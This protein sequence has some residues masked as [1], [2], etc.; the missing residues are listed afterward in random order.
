MP[1]YAIEKVMDA[2]SA[3]RE[4]GEEGLR[5]TATVLIDAIK[6]KDKPCYF[7]YKALILLQAVT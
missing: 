1:K 3:R 6:Q 4:A 2:Y 5:Q 7:N